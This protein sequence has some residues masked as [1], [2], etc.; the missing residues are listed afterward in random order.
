MSLWVNESEKEKESKQ[1]HIVVVDVLI[2]SLLSSMV[3]NDRSIDW[4]C[5]HCGFTMHFPIDLSFSN[6]IFAFAFAT[7]FSMCVHMRMILCVCVRVYKCAFQWNCIN[8]NRLSCQCQMTETFSTSLRSL[9]CF[10]FGYSLLSIT[11]CHS[12]LQLL[13]IVDVTFFGTAFSFCQLFNIDLDHL[14]LNFAGKNVC[15]THSIL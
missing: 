2:T 15:A 4:H 8:G 1:A 12:P 3:Q 5:W 10:H 7:R 6:V 11:D 14:S 13:A 9:C